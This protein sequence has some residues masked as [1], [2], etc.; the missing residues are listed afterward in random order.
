M[1]M[2]R[3]S[4]TGGLPL[5]G[6]EEKETPAGEASKAI[7]KAYRNAAGEWKRAARIAV[8]SI[9]RETSEFTT[10]EVRARLSQYGVSTHEDRALGAIMRS[11]AKQGVIEKTDRTVKSGERIN[12]NRDLRVWRS[13]I[14]ED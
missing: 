6:G 7:R 14:K 9:A 5:F 8:K 4:L 10:R 3:A 12:H 11:A 13:L 1:A 2:K